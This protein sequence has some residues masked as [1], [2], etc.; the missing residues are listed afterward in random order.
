MFWVWRKTRQRKREQNP[1]P[2]AVLAQRELIADGEFPRRW[3]R[4]L[5]R[6]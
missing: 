5:G 3:T 2:D 4:G 1:D 6:K